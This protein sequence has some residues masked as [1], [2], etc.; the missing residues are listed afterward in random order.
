MRPLVERGVRATRER[1]EPRNAD[2]ARRHDLRVTEDRERDLA[3]R[4]IEDEPSNALEIERRREHV[5]LLEPR[6]DPRTEPVRSTERAE[7]PVTGDARDRI[8]L[9]LPAG[10]RD[11]GGSAGKNSGHKREGAGPT[12]G[13]LRAARGIEPPSDAQVKPGRLLAGSE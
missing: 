5:G 8:L 4:R 13:R 6:G 9:E 11:D 7:E 12:R 10:E 1:E 3:L 2:L